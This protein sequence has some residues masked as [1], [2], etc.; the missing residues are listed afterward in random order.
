MNTPALRHH[1]GHLLTL[2]ALVG[3]EY[4]QNTMTSFASRYITGGIDA[5]PEEFS[6]A[7]TLYSAVAV[8]M[9]FQHRLLV[10]RL[11]Y[12]RFLQASL[13][14]FALGAWVSGMA[15]GMGEFLLGRAITAVGASAW[16]TGARVQVNHHRGDQRLVAVRWFAMGLFVGIGAAPLLASLLI[17]TWGWRS[18]FFITMPLAGVVSVLVHCCLPDHEPIEHE[19]P[20][21]NH[22]GGILLLV[23]GIF[24]LQ[25]TLERIPYDVF[26]DWAPLAVGALLGVAALAVYVLHDSRRHRGLIS[27]DQ[28]VDGRFIAGLMLYGFCYLVSAMSSYMTPVFLTR[29]LGF[30]PT[31]SGALLSSVAIVGVLTMNVQFA[32]SQHHR[33]LKHYVWAAMACLFV[34]G[35]W[36]SRLAGD[37]DQASLFWPLLL[38]SGVFVALAQGT[39]ALGTFQHVDERV[40]SEAYQVKNVLREVANASGVSLAT[41]VLQM[42]TNLHYHRLAEDVGHTAMWQADPAAQALGLV[43]GAAQAGGNAGQAALERLSALMSQQATLLACLDFY[44][45][46]CVLAVLAALAVACQRR[47]A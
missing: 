18:V 32:L 41:V 40:F 12:R 27:Y 36:M 10:Q 17:D 43:Q 8:V 9:I 2:S 25:F 6:L 14:C 15:N 11:G 28:F 16:F 33:Q 24:C 44:R 20:G 37:V 30:T 3:L 4:L 38:H 42:R 45:S 1:R 46:L 26:G 23:A 19:Q 21:A 34:H 35:W 47:F 39:A 29:A 22:V 7:A 31:T 13:L 5:A